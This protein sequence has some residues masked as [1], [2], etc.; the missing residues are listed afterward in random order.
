M[1]VVFRKDML[2]ELRSRTFTNA[3]LPYCLIVLVL[4]G[5]ALDPD[6]GVLTRAASGLS[7]I[8]LLFATVLCV[9]RSVDIE[10]NDDAGAMLHLSLISPTSVWLGK[11]LAI[12]AQL[13]ALS[14]VLGFSTVVLYGLNVSPIDL[15][16]LSGVALLATAALSAAGLTYALLAESARLGAGTLSLL[17]LPVCSPVLIAATQAGD[18]LLTDSSDQAA[19]WIALL[20]VMATAYVVAGSLS[21]GPL[22]EEL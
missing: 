8:A 22:L 10:T 12:W 15:L 5:F 16:V 13:G 4:F 20:G 17:V 19:R 6:S 3:A 11:W 2:I 14:A 9:Q 21:A 7:W 1:R 18:F